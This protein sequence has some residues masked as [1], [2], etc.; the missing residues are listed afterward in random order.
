MMWIILIVLVGIY[1][2]GFFLGKKCERDAIMD[3]TVGVLA[4][5]NKHNNEVETVTYYYSQEAY[6]AKIKQL[7]E[8]GEEYYEE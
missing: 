6:D 1:L 4:E 3:E 7:K 2:L 5:I 8:D